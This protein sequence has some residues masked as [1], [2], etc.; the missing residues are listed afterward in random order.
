MPKPTANEPNTN[1]QLFIDQMTRK[2]MV[3]WCDA[4][5]K[6]NKMLGPLQQSGSSPWTP[7]VYL[8]HAMDK[9]WVSK[10]GQKILSS[11]WQTATRFLKR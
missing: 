4:Y 5:L 1:E 9:G 2:F 6:S 3:D 11:G 10:D 7:S 8:Q